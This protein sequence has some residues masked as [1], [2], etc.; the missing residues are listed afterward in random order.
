MQLTYS[1]ISNDA[2]WK[3][4]SFLFLFVS[5]LALHR[6]NLNH[7]FF[8]ACNILELQVC[9]PAILCWRINVLHQGI[10]FQ[11]QFLCCFDIWKRRFGNGSLLTC[12]EIPVHRVHCAEVLFSL[13]S[14]GTSA[15]VFHS[16]VAVLLPLRPYLFYLT[17][18]H[19][20]SFHG[21]AFT[22]RTRAKHKR[23]PFLSK[24]KTSKAA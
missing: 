11:V 8:V 23:S 13:N 1:S 6:E 3:L 9:N 10:K 21:I 12:H 17:W 15:C 24:R 18:R 20:L 5:L 19:L 4:F 2:N 16:R 7:M 14:G 22:R